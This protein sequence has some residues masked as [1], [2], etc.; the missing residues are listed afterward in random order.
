MRVSNLGWG[1]SLFLHAA[2]GSPPCRCL[3]SSL[4]CT[5]TYECSADR[6]QCDHMSRSGGLDGNDNGD[7]FDE[8]GFSVL[9]FKA[10]FPRITNDQCFFYVSNASLCSSII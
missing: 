1:L 3:A 5:E 7:D 8:P 10:N 9:Y 2:P 6:D 4:P